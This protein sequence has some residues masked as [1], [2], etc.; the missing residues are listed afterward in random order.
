MESRPP[1]MQVDDSGR[2][3]AML[4]IFTVAALIVAG[5][6]WAL[7]AVGGLWM[8]GLAFAVHVA[9]TSLVALVVFSV[10]EGRT[11]A[12]G[13]RGRSSPRQGRRL[14]RRPQTQSEAVTAL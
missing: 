13:N 12:I 2:G 9:M 7:A 4:L 8:L 3:L 5:A 10:I 6:V 14:E 1:N 11:L